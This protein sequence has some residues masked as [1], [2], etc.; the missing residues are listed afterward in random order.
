MTNNNFSKTAAFIWSVAELLRSDFKQSQYGRVILPFTLLRR[1]EEVMEES[2]ELVFREASDSEKII[3]GLESTHAF[4]AIALDGI[5][6]RLLNATKTHANPAGLPFFNR[7]RLRLSELNSKDIKGELEHYIG[8]FSGNI[9]EIF[10]YFDFDEFVSLLDNANLLQKVVKKFADA[11]LSLTAISNHEMGLVFEELIHRFAESSNETAG[12][13]FT[14]RDIARLTTSLLFSEDESALTKSGYRCTVYDPAAGSGG[15]LSSSMEHMAEYN[16]KAAINVF[17]Q[18]INSE[19]YTI[20]KALMLMKGQDITNIKLGNTLSNDQLPETKFDYILSNPP[21]SLDWKRIRG[22]IVYEHD[23]YGFD[24]R[25]GAGIPRISDGS[26][27]FLMHM[28]SKMRDSSTVDSINVDGSRIGIILNGSPSFTGGAG[29]GESEI[30][31]YIL[32]N[33][34][35]EAIVALPTDMFYNTGI[36][37]YIWLLSN[38]KAQSHKGK[39]QLIDASKLFVKMRKPL[40]SKRNVMSVENINTIT[41]ALSKFKDIDARSTAENQAQSYASKIV[42]IHEF[43]YRRLTIDRPLRLSAQFTDEAVQSLRFAPKPFN[44]VMPKIYERFG[45]A[46]SNNNYG[47]LSNEESQVRALIKVDFPELR[48]NE[49]KTLLDSKI[50]LNQKSLMDKAKVLHGEIGSL[51]SDD[52]NHFNRLFQSAIKSTRINLT[53]KE[54]KQLTDAITWKNQEAEPVVEKE[55]QERAQPIYGKFEYKGKVVKFKQDG[56]LRD[57]EDLQLDPNKATLELIE[58]YFNRE[59]AP[60]VGDAWV[61]DDKVDSQDK[62]VGLVGYQINFASKF[63]SSRARDQAFSG[64]S[65]RIKNIVTPSELGV[66]ALDEVSGKVVEYERLDV[67]KR[68]LNLVR[69][70]I[71][72]SI[73]IP[74]YYNIFLAQDEGSDWLD[75]Y[76]PIVSGTRRISFHS[77]KNSRLILTSVKKQLD[78]V[79]L[80]EECDAVLTRMALLKKSA[81]NDFSAAQEQIRPFQGVASR[82]E[83]EFSSMLPTPLAILWELAESKFNGREQ[84]EAFIKFYEY[85]GFYLVSIAFGLNKPNREKLYRNKKGKDLV[86][87]TMAYGYQRLKEY[88]P[89]AQNNS[90][91]LESIYNQEV[92]DLLSEATSL[93]NDMAHRGLPSAQSVSSALKRVNSFN[94]AIQTNLR[95]FFEQSTLIKPM[96]SRFDGEAYYYEVEILKGLG[97]N[98]SKTAVLKTNEPMVY[99]ELYLVNGEISDNEAAST[100]KLFPLIVMDE[101]IK[102]SEMMGFYFYSDQKEDELRYVCPYPNVETYKFKKKELLTGNLNDE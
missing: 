99:G 47:V 80:F 91:M 101:T 46:W 13:H 87:L 16:P 71:N 27:L 97:I 29:S 42:D 43:G 49:I 20:C 78:L 88:Q 51:R 84:C 24:G 9:R 67:K 102:E 58:L 11:E 45:S 55:L 35:L 21:F 2:R 62:E 53:A 26:L 32:E 1:L 4:A 63:E 3:S 81:F 92:I 64:I 15:F 57:N 74:G 23:T 98:P 66:Y 75:S 48:G 41:Q 22:E 95:R 89:L 85:L 93:R 34:L 72:T 82:Y 36:A 56:D 86:G 12:E 7:S 100:F 30:R 17:A 6:E 83:L 33:D 79:G 54:K 10:E 94:D 69:F 68:T 39:V 44:T 96:Q 5:E 50:W 8:C 76:F 40:G 77:W 38:K 73:L 25:Y 52:F 18:E 60:H 37:T 28:I 65:H 70:D 61:N 31:R 19:S 14:P 59:I 90:A